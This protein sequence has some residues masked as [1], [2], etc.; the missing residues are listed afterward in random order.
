MLHT[1]KA[2]ATFATSCSCP[3]FPTLC[4]PPSRV[5]RAADLLLASRLQRG[6]VVGGSRGPG[7]GQ[8]VC[9][10]QDGQEVLAGGR[11]KVGYQS[12]AVK[13]TT[14]LRE[15]IQPLILVLH[16]RAGDVL[17]LGVVGAEAWRS[18][19]AE[20]LAV[21]VE[22]AAERVFCGCQ[23]VQGVQA[24]PALSWWSRR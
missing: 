17:A 19:A 20:G 7:G 21:V 4:C 6:A 13:V 1:Y 8:E 14:Q 15:E 2:P 16:L 24:T 5:G 18:G 3:S 23:R 11:L 22:L 9:L 12:E 10:L